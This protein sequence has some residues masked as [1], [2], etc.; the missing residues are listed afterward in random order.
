[1]RRVVLIASLALV[2]LALW[3]W[4]FGGAARLSAWANAG[5]E[6]VQ[7]ALAG[8][9]RALRAGACVFETP[10]MQVLHHG[11]RTWEEAGPLIHRYW[12]GTGAMYAKQ[13]RLA[14]PSTLLL[15]VGLARR[16]AFGRSRVAKSLGQQPQRWRR[17]AD[18]LS[19]FA[20]GLRA[21]LD[22]GTSHFHPRR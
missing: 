13:L 20:V 12:F 17:L 7:R 19:G 22:R 10:Q 18:F 6:Q 21:P 8:G 9:L 14:P 2:A 5:Q 11:F 4:G 1:M 16:W 3:L 15:L